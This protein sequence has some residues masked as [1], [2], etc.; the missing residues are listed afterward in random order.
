MST[1]AGLNMCVE[2]LLDNLKRYPQDKRSTYRC[3]QKVGSQHPELVLPLVPQFLNIHPFF[4]M[5]E[6][7]VETPQCKRKILFNFHLYIFNCFFKVNIMFFFLL[8]ICLLILI[9]NAAQHSLTILPLLEP[10]TIRH[11]LYLRDTMSQYVPILNLPDSNYSSVSRP[12]LVPESLAFLNNI[13]N[14]L[15]RAE[16]KIR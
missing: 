13:I 8:D 6:P 2:K 1:T 12:M 10:H 3:L 5:A 11:Y 15:E 7:D 4:D 9:L 14:N 16:N